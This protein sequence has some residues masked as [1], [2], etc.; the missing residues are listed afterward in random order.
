MIF[1]GIKIVVG[2][3]GLMNQT[4]H[5]GKAQHKAQGPLSDVG[6]IPNGKVTMRLHHNGPDH[7]LSTGS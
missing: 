4:D 6:L 2:E 7:W 1:N 3:L 5:R